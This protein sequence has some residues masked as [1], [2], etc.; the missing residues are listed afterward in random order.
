MIER[1]DPFGRTMSLRQMMDRLME[2]AFIMPRGGQAGGMGSAAMDVYEEGDN[3]IV[4][5]HLPG[6]KS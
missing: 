5:A 2:D 1:Y 4:E 3:L 6:V